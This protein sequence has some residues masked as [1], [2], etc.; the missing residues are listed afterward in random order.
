M[1][2][3]A[4]HSDRRATKECRILGCDCR[5]C[6]SQA[7]YVRRRV[8]RERWR[9]AKANHP[10]KSNRE[11]EEE[12]SAKGPAAGAGSAKGALPP[13]GDTAVQQLGKCEVK[14][15]RLL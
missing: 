1:K 10:T 4:T 6:C 5:L 14:L 7:A 2:P 12:L 15:L 13:G 11:L 9:T 8:S 3:D